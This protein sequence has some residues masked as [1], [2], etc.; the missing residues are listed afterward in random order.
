MIDPRRNDNGFNNC[1]P[2]RRNDN[3]FSSNVIDR[4]RLLRTDLFPGLG[5]I[6]SANLFN[7][8]ILPDWQRYPTTGW[9]HW[10]RVQAESLKFGDCV[11]P[12]V[13]RTHHIGKRSGSTVKSKWQR[14]SL[15]AMAELT[16]IKHAIAFAEVAV[17]SVGP[18]EKYQYLRGRVS[19]C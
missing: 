16:D 13:P 10:L 5:W 2:P 8:K 18:S 4:S 7:E 17:L 1:S 15:A 14:D 9:D 3:G 12:E 11:Y 19:A 6:S